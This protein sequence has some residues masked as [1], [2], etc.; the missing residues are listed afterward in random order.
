M[1][2]LLPDSDEEFKYGSNSDSEF[3]YDEEGVV[4]PEDYAV[5]E[6]PLFID[7]MADF[8]DSSVL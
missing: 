1:F 2:V 8:D 6:V 7:L 3:E 5:L 4:V